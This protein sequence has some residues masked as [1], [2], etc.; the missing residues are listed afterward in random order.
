MTEG[1]YT[2]NVLLN[3]AA[4]VVGESVTAQAVSNEFRINAEDS[5]NFRM[6]ILTTTSTVAVGITAKLQ[7]SWDGGATWFA[8]GSRAQ[9][10]IT[11]DDSFEISLVVTD[12]SD[13]AQLPLYPLGRLVID[14]GAGDAVTITEIWKVCRG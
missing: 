7:H 4:Q 10:A 14:T 9:V 13:A 8:V 5:L 6:S 3:G 12:T 11:G 1:H 2:K